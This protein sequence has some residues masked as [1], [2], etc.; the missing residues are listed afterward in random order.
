MG[1]EIDEFFECD[2]IRFELTPM[3]A[4]VLPGGN[5]VVVQKGRWMIDRYIELQD[6]FS[7]SNVV[8]L[9]LFDGGS[10]VLLSAMFA[11]HRLLAVELSTRPLVQLD[12]H[13]EDRELT[14]RI[15]QALGV[16]QSDRST[17]A[18]LVHDCFGDAPLDLVIDDASHLYGASCASFDL[19]F[20]LL[21]PGGLYI[22]ED[23]SHEHELEHGLL[24]AIEAGKLSPTD[25]LSLGSAGDSPTP[26]GQL[27][28][29]L[30]A[31]A[32]SGSAVIRD[33]RIQRGWME[34]RRGDAQLSSDTFDR[35]GLI[36][37]MA[38]SLLAR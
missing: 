15:T 9:G 19:L 32:A 5:A 18:K 28:L 34:V 21:R 3:S 38:A 12:E 33:L 20:P 4:H 2:G 30:V 27:A 7:R 8:E 36:G 14:D 29:E 24:A 17:V 31:I 22:I 26:L 6:E 11:P 37:P 23:W 25:L 35:R 13:I 1:A 10:T 16:D